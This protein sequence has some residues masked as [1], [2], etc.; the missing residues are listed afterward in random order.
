MYQH[1][2][3]KILFI[4]EWLK[5]TLRTFWAYFEVLG[6]KTKIFSKICLI[7]LIY[8]QKLNCQKKLNYEVHF[9]NYCEHN[10]S[11]IT[12]GW[13]WAPCTRHSDAMH[14][15]RFSKQSYFPFQKI[16]ISRTDHHFA[17]IILHVIIMFINCF[18]IL[19]WFHCLN[20]TAVLW[21]WTSDWCLD[22]P[23]YYSF[24]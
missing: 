17:L 5:S 10:T 3:F 22:F 6:V 4:L 21:N 12:L 1:L 13:A 2:N 7:C 8:F 15:G 16:L 23:R 18:E 11:T 9:R 20:V 24:A 19:Y 14:R